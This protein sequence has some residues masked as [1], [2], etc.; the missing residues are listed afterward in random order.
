MVVPKR[1]MAEGPMR[2]EGAGESFGD[3]QEFVD[4]DTFL[5]IGL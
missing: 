5:V 2:D 1:T 3:V 4:E